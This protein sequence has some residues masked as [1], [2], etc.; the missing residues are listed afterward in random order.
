MDKKII[1]SFIAI[2][3]LA[4]ILFFVK[5]CAKE[6]SSIAHPVIVISPEEVFEGGVISFADTTLNAS[7]YEWNFGDGSPLSTEPSGNHQYL[8]KGHYRITLKYDQKDILTYPNEIVV[9]EPP[10]LFDTS[11]FSIS[12]PE[13]A[14]VN[15][16]VVFKVA[17]K[18]KGVSVYEWR[19]G[20]S[21]GIDSRE[22][23]A[24]H[25]YTKPDRYEI[26]LRVNNSQSLSRKAILV[27]ERTPGT[28]P[29]ITADG[30]QHL[31]EKLI[32]AGNDADENNNV[33]KE[34][35]RY[36]CGRNLA[37]V[38]ETGEPKQTLQQFFTSLKMQN[39]T[40]VRIFH[41]TKDKQSGCISSIE[42]KS[43]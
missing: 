22:M 1:F 19:F 26:T 9:T 4:A 37:G 10:A 43:E 41:I 2:I 5:K 36:F 32:A 14:F 42:A 3:S 15:E 20:E 35:E 27:K 34:I 12:G 17:S 28:Y 29:L 16:R 24:S 38:I 33:R 7:T 40:S 13:S 39:K 8:K 25:V 21:G 6:N 23:T 31:F 30:L 11:Q 18:E